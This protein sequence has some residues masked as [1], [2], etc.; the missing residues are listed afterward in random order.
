MEELYIENILI[1]DSITLRDLK[2]IKELFKLRTE[3]RYV[4]HKCIGYM[5]YDIGWESTAKEIVCTYKHYFLKGF[6]DNDSRIT[7]V[8][9]PLHYITT[10]LIRLLKSDNP[11]K[12]RF[13]RKYNSLI[14]FRE[15]KINL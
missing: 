14:I 11:I 3:P 2:T 8:K 6:K 1:H 7:W 15:N 12:F 4:T 13:N 5:K 10:T 9:H